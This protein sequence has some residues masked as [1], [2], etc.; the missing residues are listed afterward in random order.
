MAHLKE[1]HF[2]FRK[3]CVITGNSIVMMRTED[4]DGNVF[5][6]IVRYLPEQDE[7]TGQPV[8]QDVKSIID[9][10]GES[11]VFFNLENMPNPTPAEHT[12]AVMSQLNSI[13]RGI[14]PSGRLKG[15]PLEDLPVALLKWHVTDEFQAAPVIRF[16]IMAACLGTLLNIRDFSSY[17]FDDSI[18]RYTPVTLEGCDVSGCRKLGKLYAV[19]LIFKGKDR[20]TFVTSKPYDD[21]D[22]VDITGYFD[23]NYDYQSVAFTKI[24]E[25][26]PRKKKYS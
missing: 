22:V 20:I 11:G 23:G 1:K 16:A 15:V 21:G 25:K 10:M 4:S 13:Q 5:D 9:I 18:D 17:I 24:V 7:W 26:K 19:E 8:K 6:S 2:F 14:Y 3:P 12:A